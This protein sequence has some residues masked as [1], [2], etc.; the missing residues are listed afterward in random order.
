MALTKR[1]LATS[2]NQFAK[3]DWEDAFN[4][5]SLLTE[6]EREIKSMA[7]QYCQ[8]KL[9]PRVTEGFRH[10]TF[11][12]SMMKEMGSLGLLGATIEGYGCSGVSS[13][14][15]GLIAREVER[16]DSGYRSAMSVQSS[17]VMHPIHT[18]GTEAQREKYL[19][20]LATGELIGCFGLTEPNHGSDPSG[21][22]TRATKQ[23][24]GSFKISGSKT[25]ITNSPIADVFIIW[26][27]VNEETEKG[28]KDRIRGFILERGMNGIETPVIKGKMSL[29]ASVTGMIMMDEVSVPADN[30]LPGVHGLKVIT[31]L[32]FVKFAF[33]EYSPN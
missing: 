5:E 21:M 20:R 26:A 31:M 17:L 29:R 28:P 32:I 9:L 14:S 8:E 3:F 25:W 6:E 10:E 33:E 12:K 2:S 16:V 30:M 18:F 11:D 13:V 27:K 15:Y 19:P 23:P 22:E 24:D 1:S 4:L 7:N